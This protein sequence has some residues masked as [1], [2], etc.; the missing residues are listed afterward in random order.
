MIALYLASVVGTWGTR[1]LGSNG[2]FSVEAMP[3]PPQR[4][5]A[6]TPSEPMLRKP[7]EL[8]KP[9]EVANYSVGSMS[10]WSAGRGH[11]SVSVCRLNKSSWKTPM[12]NGYT[13]FLSCKT[14]FVNTCEHL[15]RVYAW[16]RSCWGRLRLG[17]GLLLLPAGRQRHLKRSS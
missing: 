5:E 6:E 2:S 4:H 1:H 14:L 7:R 16:K 11:R 3:A 8:F 10:Q 13:G 15:S 12:L 17:A 9:A